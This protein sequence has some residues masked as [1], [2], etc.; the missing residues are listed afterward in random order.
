MSRPS[1]LIVDDEQHMVSL[2]S[3][4]LR[5]EGYKV[6]TCDNGP[7]ALALISAFDVSLVVLD[8]NMPGMTGTD[9]ARQI[10]GKAPVLMVTARPEIDE[11][12]D[13]NINAVVLKPFSPM[14][15]AG[16]VQELIGP[17]QPPKEQSA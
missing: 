4:T 6:L 7:R 9:L 3:M 8:H 1:I 14:E 16:K 5:R 12:H 13:P 11:S 17:G 2:L 15:L 10:G